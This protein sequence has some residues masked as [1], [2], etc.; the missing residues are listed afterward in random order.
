VPKHD[1]AWYRLLPEKIE[2]IGQRTSGER[3]EVRQLDIAERVFE[4]T[5]R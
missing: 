2:K 4:S 1:L 3:I 5:S